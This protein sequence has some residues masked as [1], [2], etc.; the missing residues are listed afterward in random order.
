MEAR[1][2]PRVQLRNSREGFLTPETESLKRVPANKKHVRREGTWAK[3]R[4]HSRWNTE[5]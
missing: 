1:A 3:T 5:L 4:K 2:D